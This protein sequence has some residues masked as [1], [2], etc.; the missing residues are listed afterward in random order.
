MMKPPTY[1]EISWYNDRF[2]GKLNGKWSF[3]EEGTGSKTKHIKEWNEFF[4]NH[5]Q[6]L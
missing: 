4:I 5:S 6:S 2:K 3:L 1:D